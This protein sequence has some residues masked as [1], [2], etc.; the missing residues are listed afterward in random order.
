MSIAVAEKVDS[1]RIV[2]GENASAELIYT[3]GGSDSDTAIKTAVEAAAPEE[4]EGLSRQTIDIEPVTVDTVNQRGLWTATVRYGRMPLNQIGGTPIYNFETGGGTQHI[5]QSLST[6]RYPSDT[7]PDFKGAIG[8][9]GGSV[10]GVD[11][12]VPVYNWS[13][14]HRLSAATVT[15]AYRSTLFGLTGKVNDATWREFAAGEVL[16]LGASGS[17]RGEDEWEITFKF[18]ASP[19]RSGIQVGDIGGIEKGGWEYLWVYYE[20]DI[21]N[22]RLLKKPTAV[23]VE[24]VYYSGSFSSLGI[25]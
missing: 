20:D 14:T 15:T 7:A 22:N 10:Q 19:K 13:E 25:S 6:T 17:R 11:I 18:A 23:F 2:T 21:S 3:V 9:S 1:R 12:T 5:T 24:Q 8:V 4:Y 16:F